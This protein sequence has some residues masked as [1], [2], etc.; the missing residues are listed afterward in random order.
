MT[1]AWIYI[2]QCCDGSYYTGMTQ[3]LERRIAQHQKGAYKGYTS[4]RLPVKLVYTKDFPSYKEAIQA[5]RQIKTWSRAKKEALIKDDFALLHE[6]AKC[7]NKSHYK[8]K[9]QE[10]ILSCLD[11]ARH[12]GDRGLSM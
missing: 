4:K 11:Y 5:E 6:L 3:N 8:I 7:R 1:K 9:K 12:E 2:L 10:R